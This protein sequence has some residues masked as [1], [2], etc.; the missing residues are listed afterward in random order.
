MNC[1][2]LLVFALLALSIIP[3][4][5]NAQTIQEPPAL[6]S[7][8]RILHDSDQHLD[9]VKLLEAPV[10][11]DTVSS[12]LV[13]F[14]ARALHHLGRFEQSQQ[15]LLI[16]ENDS[17]TG[18]RALN[19][20]ANQANQQKQYLRA[21]GYLNMLI[22]RQPANPNYWLRKA[23]IFK[24]MEEYPAAEGSLA[25]AN[26]LDSLNQMV[27]IEWVDV[28]LRM[29]ENRRALGRANY[30]LNI[31]PDNLELRRLKTIALYRL[32]QMKQVCEEA[33]VL[34]LLGDTTDVI[35]KYKAFALYE[36]DSLDKA[37]QW[38]YWLLEKGAEGEDIYYYLGK[39]YDKRGLKKE[40][41]HYFMQASQLCISPNFRPMALQT[42]INMY[43]I[44]MHQESVK[45]LQTLRTFSD[46]PLIFFYLAL[47]YDKLYQDK[48]PTLNHLRLFVENSSRKDEEELR[49]YAGQK[50][51]QLTEDLHFQ[52][53]QF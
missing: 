50:I 28:L 14:Y 40:A 39:V 2:K 32:K 5:L 25:A 11:A 46:N 38:L 44:G 19:L 24:T 29:D 17:L 31:A 37:A 49:Y 41:Q 34:T 30:A 53:I 1:S 8:I 33:Q 51:K 42:G 18:T 16:I 4:R 22:E 21:I 27:Y 12:E 48:I 36:T 47:N 23:R 35:I 43:E 3:A 20:L 7:Q 6:R 15:Y 9:I 45:W 13:W 26:K 10:T 52:G